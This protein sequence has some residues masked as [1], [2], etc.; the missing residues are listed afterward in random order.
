MTAFDVEAVRRRFSSLQTGFGFFDAPGGSQVPD[1]VGTAIANTLRDASANLGAPYP[2]GARVESILDRSK[3]AGARFFNC[4]PAEVVFGANMTTLN[5]ALSRVFGR[6][7]KAGD[8]ILVTRLDHDGNVAPWVELADDLGLVVQHV[9]INA[10]S[11]L[12]LGDLEAKLSDRT[13]VVSFP[14]AS[15]VIGTL[16]DARRVCELAHAAGAIAWVDAVHYA[17]HEAM[18]VHAIDADVVL[19][20]PYKF[21][22]PHLGMA[23]VRESLAETWRPYKARPSATTPTARRFETGTLPYELLGGLLATFAYL[24]DIGGMDAI[25]TYERSLGERFLAGLTDAATVYG[26]PTMEGRVPTFLLNLE[27]IPARDV[28]LALAA[29]DMG[30]WSHDTYYA[31]GLY[32]R[33]G[34]DEAVRLG[35]IH[36]NTPDEVD[37]LNDELAKLAERAPLHPAAR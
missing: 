8:E 22:G 24:D 7:L 11:T 21:C 3:A 13:R 1:E 14:W 12:D 9:D 23:Y 29:R 33:L 19:C 37:R 4:S 15:N 34:Y 17:A 27:G 6:E 35:F 18:D 26:L 31:L 16:V 36:Y 30:V 10:D 5:F 25:R 32:P 20:S 2:T 28:S